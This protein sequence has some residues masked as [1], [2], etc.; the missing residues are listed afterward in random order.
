M[1]RVGCSAGRTPFIAVLAGRRSPHSDFL[2][3][4]PRPGPPIDIFVAAVVGDH[5]SPFHSP[6]AVSSQLAV[7]TPRLLP[8]WLQPD[9]LG[10]A[11]V[12]A[13][14]VRLWAGVIRL[15][16]RSQVLNVQLSLAS[17]LVGAAALS[18]LAADSS[19]LFVVVAGLVSAP[20]S[21]LSLVLFGVEV[22]CASIIAIPRH[23]QGPCGRY[24]I[25]PAASLAGHRAVDNSGSG[26][27]GRAGGSGGWRVAV[28]VPDGQ[29]RR[30]GRPTLIRRW[31][32]TGT[33]Q[34]VGG[35]AH[36][37]PVDPARAARPLRPLRYQLAANRGALG[38]DADGLPVVSAPQVMASV[39]ATAACKR[40]SARTCPPA[41]NMHAAR[42]AE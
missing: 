28:G 15:S 18:A 4:R 23:P 33:G 9:L 16:A 3:G 31:L 36:R 2:D 20:V 30:A 19:R 39:T 38:L 27:G 41:C 32:T 26:A 24:I 13:T 17:G 6:G 25:R 10:H 42:S 7:A 8:R 1:R 14:A 5:L 29:R 12:L 21:P 22:S 11:L 40:H 37:V 35:E 34:A